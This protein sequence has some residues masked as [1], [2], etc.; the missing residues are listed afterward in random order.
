VRNLDRI[1]HAAAGRPCGEQGKLPNAKAFMLA[2]RDKHMSEQ[3]KQLGYTQQLKMWTRAT[4]I[5]PLEEA[6]NAKFD[7]Q[8][9]EE[10]CEAFRAKM[11]ES[12]R[13][14][15]KA[16]SQPQNATERRPMSYVRRSDNVA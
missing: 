2:E 12:Y 8:I 5:R 15:L 10:I 16:K 3:G 4:I 1:G 13:N 6:F 9:V 14:G 7:D 11:L